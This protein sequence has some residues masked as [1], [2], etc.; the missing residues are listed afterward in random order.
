MASD[1]SDALPDSLKAVLDQHEPETLVAIR[2]YCDSALEEYDLQ[3]DI[4]ERTYG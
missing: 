1:T 3:T 4:D 2:N